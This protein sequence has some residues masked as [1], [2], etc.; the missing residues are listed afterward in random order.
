MDIPAPQKYHPEM[1][2]SPFLNDDDTQLYQSYIGIL[3]WAVEL[4]R[5]DLS[6]VA[7]RMACFS[8]APRKGHLHA[9][10]LVFG[11]CKKH[12]KSKIVFDHWKKDWS[13]VDWVE[14]DW[15]SFY[16]DVRGK[17]L[18]PNMPEPRGKGVQINL[19]L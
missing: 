1:D 2:T 9:L 10:L 8:A 17:S 12:D 3:R 5:V 6:F 7:G 13:K 18:P 16:E 14:Y 4:G 15:R 19:F 11:Y